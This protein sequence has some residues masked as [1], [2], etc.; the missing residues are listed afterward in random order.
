MMTVGS[1]ETDLTGQGE[2]GKKLLKL[3]QKKKTQLGIVDDGGH[4]FI[5]DEEISTSSDLNTGMVECKQ[6][7]IWLIIVATVLLFGI[8]QVL[9]AFYEDK[10]RE[11]LPQNPRVDNFIKTI[12]HP[13]SFLIILP[14]V[15][16][17]VMTILGRYILSAIRYPYQN[18]IIRE[19]LD[20]GNASKFGQEFAHYLECLVY[21]L[22]IQAGMNRHQPSRTMSNFEIQDDDEKY[23]YLTFTEVKNTIDL[24]ALYLDVNKKVVEGKKTSKLFQ[25]FTA[26]MNLIKIQLTKIKIEMPVFKIGSKHTTTPTAL[27]E[28]SIWSYFTMVSQKTSAQKEISNK[29]GRISK[30]NP[31]PNSTGESTRE[32]PRLI[33]TQANIDEI[34]L[35][36]DCVNDFGIMVNKASRSQNSLIR[37][38][39]YFLCFC[40]CICLRSRC[41]RHMNYRIYQSS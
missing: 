38:C 11:K 37:I 40:N 8:F 23:D 17:L 22:R 3:M 34:D 35:L 27:S 1:K 19:S 31:S 16:L 9:V 20:R 2:F 36:D 41:R 4:R 29:F 30:E 26:N 39:G 12:A 7:C 14:I 13:L 24:L 25:Q 21:T 10:L 5:L 18:A 28:Q 32:L 33:V 15:N 6:K